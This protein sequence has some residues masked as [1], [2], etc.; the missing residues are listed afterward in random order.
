MAQPDTGGSRIARLRTFRPDI[1]GFRA[2]A[3]IMV[4]IH[5][6]GFPVF[7]GVDTSFVLS[8]FLVTSLLLREVARTGAVAFGAFYARR[9]RRLLPVATLVIVA[10][11]LAAW[12]WL[13]SF[14]LKATGLDGLFAALSAINWRLAATSTDYFAD[15]ATTSPFQH[16]WSLAVEEQFYLVWPLL[17]LAV[18]WL[19]AKLHRHIM[20]VGVTLAAVVGV[21]LY[22]SVTITRTA[23]P[24]AYFG[25]H[26]RAWELAVGALVA[27][28]AHVFARM[29]QPLAAL[30]SWAGLAAI[31]VG[32]VMI[33]HSR[34]IPGSVMLWPVIGT[35]M[36]II[37]GCAAPRFGAELLLGR[38]PV[39][40]IGRTSYS[41]YLWHWPVLII[42]PYA[43]GFQPNRY[44]S[45]ALVGGSLGLAV[46]TYR[47]VE[48]P[49]K[50]VR[51]L[52]E[53]PRRGLAFGARFI[54]ASV[55]A[56]GSLLATTVAY[57]SPA[58]T[59]AAQFADPAKIA[60]QVS[61][62]AN[63]T[64]LAGHAAQQ[65]AT[66]KDD[67]YRGC[68]ADINDTVA[69]ACK[70][71][72]PS[73]Q[74]QVVL[75]GSS[76]AWQWIPPLNGIVRQKGLG[77][78]VFAKGSCPAEQYTVTVYEK[79]S[80]ESQ[81]QASTYTQCDAWRKDA[82]AK[83][84]A[85]HPRLVIMSS[86]VEEQATPE[87]I[88]ASVAYFRGLGA[89]VAVIGET[90][91]LGFDGPECLAAHPGDLR[92]CMVARSAAVDQS[93]KDMATRAAHDAGATVIDPLP[94]LCSTE[95]CPTI[96]DDQIVYWD[97]HHLTAGYSAW[98]APALAA[99]LPP[100]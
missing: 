43:L 46:L 60:G 3:I 80:K 88:K 36:F 73:A 76:L 65:V 21:S 94:W 27:V 12:V 6:A 25:F 45:L 13:P 8:G 33:A 100:F 23:Q 59:H 53:R 50:Q 20:A 90:P 41:W 17:F 32:S 81:A 79:A 92:Q 95:R 30:V 31:A 87:A 1:E 16:F 14:K 97:D 55:L 93:L 22:L 5:H 40:A 54:A 67:Q 61:D 42:A 4:V 48:V 72:Q 74:E 85:L 96:I 15:N 56:A 37:G 10:T 11:L 28:G 9:A 52:V 39:R 35:A 24:W 63:A 19:G 57:A 29:W 58:T 26:T 77:L 78:S 98:L 66:V 71:G 2:L 82:Y 75:L 91:A 69:N 44:Q 64:K 7:G 83:I 18:A 99:T 62:A 47:L 38:I 89:E 51:S 49:M 86:R 68:I 70:L 84:A 34:E